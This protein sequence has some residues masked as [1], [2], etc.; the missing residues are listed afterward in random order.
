[1]SEI[2]N[3]RIENRYSN[4]QVEFFKQLIDKIRKMFFKQKDKEGQP[5]VN[6]KLVSQIMGFSKHYVGQGLKMSKEA[7]PK[8]ED[9]KTGRDY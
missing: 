1:M 3:L 9:E 8:N 2:F 5:K 7:E 6:E 4:R